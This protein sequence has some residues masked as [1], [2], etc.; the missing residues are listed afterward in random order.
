[1]V[2]N[3]SDSINS[4]T[5]TTT[6]VTGHIDQPDSVNDNNKSDKSKQIEKDVDDEDEDKGDEDKGDEDKGDE[7][8]GDEDKGDED[9]GDEDKGDEDKGDEEEGK[10]EGEGKDQVKMKTGLDFA[11]EA[12]ATACEEV[13]RGNSLN[14]LGYII[15]VQ[16]AARGKCNYYDACFQDDEDPLYHLTVVNDFFDHSELLYHKTLYHR[17]A[18]HNKLK[19][20]SCNPLNSGIRWN[21][22]AIV[23]LLEHCTQLE[24]V[25]FGGNIGTPKRLPGQDLAKIAVGFAKNTSVTRIILW[26]TWVTVGSVL[27]LLRNIMSNG[28]SA[29]KSINL[30]V[31]P[32]FSQVDEETI[33]NYIRRSNVYV[34]F[35]L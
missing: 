14:V 15:A 3:I 35:S 7:D 5:T 1:M 18:K 11:R 34:E 16:S 17:I 33:R 2:D 31:S 25:N 29:V 28:N 32:P 27:V 9:K 30:A 21:P 26:D 24:L 10:E 8:K 19:K 4:T 13:K 6:V 20:L 23:Y 22:E 12:L